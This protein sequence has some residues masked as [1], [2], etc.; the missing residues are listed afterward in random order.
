[1]PLFDGK[2]L[3]GWNTGDG[4]GQITGWTV[5]TTASDLVTDEVFGDF[6]FTFSV[7]LSANANSGVK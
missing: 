1:V 3:K 6:E 7:R 2:T 5:V 4:A